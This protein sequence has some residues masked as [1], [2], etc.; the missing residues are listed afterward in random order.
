MAGLT[1][2]P[3]PRLSGT[4]RVPGDKSISHRSLIVSALAI[5]RSHVSGL[6]EGEDVLATAS[7][8]RALGVGIERLDDHRWRVDGV[9]VGGLA[10]PDDVLDMGNSGTSARLLLG[11]L[12]SHPIRAVMTGDASLRRRPMDRVTAPLAACGAQFE[13]RAGRFLPLTVTGATDPLPIDYTLQVA[14]A[15]VKSAILLAG[16]NAPGRTMVIEP[17]ASRDHT[18]RMLKAMGAD[19][20]I[21]EDRAGRRI[22]VTGEA[23][24][25][26]IDW[27]VP[28]DI[29]SAAFPLVA[30]LLA[31]DGEVRIESVGTNPLRTGILEALEAMG[32]DVTLA[33][34]REMGG[35]PVADLIARPSRLRAIDLDPVLA[36]RLIDECPI[37]FVAAAFATGRSR[38]TGLEEL[39]VKESD[40]ITAMASGL[41]AC[42]VSVRELPDGLEID[43]GPVAGGATI[44]THLDHRIA[45]S[46]TVLGLAAEAPV[47]LDDASPIATSFPGFVELMAGLGAR[48]VTA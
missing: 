47:A 12:A 30:G 14:S 48:L 19:L 34:H 5:G 6:L 31:Q 15:Q 44:T 1:A 4:V 45:M 27:Q 13:A 28:G 18:E 7:A 11:L 2:A 10:E 16:L 37:L 26:P 39:R 43:G 40:R 24:L 35:E 3:S 38:F 8:L 22:S 42:G 21:E 25:R 36:P 33:D 23:E 20:Q 29:S 17:V 32:A 46:F 9:G 41:A